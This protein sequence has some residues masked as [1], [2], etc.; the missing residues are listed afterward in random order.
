MSTLRKTI[1]DKFGH[2]G[3]Y[4][5]E[6]H[7]P[8]LIIFSVIIAVLIY[9]IPNVTI[10]TSTNAMIPAD[11]PVRK[12]YNRFKE[13]FGREDLIFILIRSPE[14]FHEHFLGRLTSFHHELEEKVPYV[15][16]VVSMINARYIF[17]EKDELVVE[18]LLYDRKSPMVTMPMLKQRVMKRPGYVNYLI[19]EDGKYTALVVEKEVYVKTNDKEPDILKGFENNFSDETTEEQNYFDEKQ[20]RELITAIWEIV[21]QYQSDD[22]SI[23]VTGGMLLYDAL[24]R[25]VVKDLFRSVFLG[26][27]VMV[28]FLL[29]LFRNYS[30]VVL[31]AVIV[32]SSMLSTMGIMAVCGI[33]MKITTTMLPAF[34]LAVGVGDSVHILAIFYRHYDKEQNKKEAVIYSLSHSGLAIL[35]TTLTTAAGLLSFS[36]AELTVIADIGIFAAVGV[37]LALIFTIFLLPALLAAIPI[38]VSKKKKRNHRIVMDRI[39]LFFAHFSVSHPWKILI[40]TL[41]IIIVSI[42]F[43][44]Q[45]RV[46][47][48]V[49]NWFPDGITIKEDLLLID[50]KIKG[51]VS[52]EIVVDTQNPGGVYDPE[53]LNKI[54][55]LKGNISKI[56]VDKLHVGKIFTVNDIIKEIHEALH[57]NNEDFYSIPQ[58][59]NVIAQELLLFENSG[60]ND[61]D[62]IVDNR[63]QKTR[64]SIKTP[65]SD[66]VVFVD[67]IKEV[68]G[69]FKE[70]FGERVLITTTGVMAIAA[71]VITA[72]IETMIRSYG[73]AFFVISIMMIFL[74]GN[75]KIG[76]LS[77]VPNL[78][79]VL[80]VMG[81]MGLCDFP[82]DMVSL[83][84]GS[85]VIGLAVDDTVHFIYNF[86]KN[87]E[88]TNDADEAVKQTLLSTG[89]AM[90]ITSLVL[91]SGF[92]VVMFSTLTIMKGF[93][94]FTGLAV[95]L[96][97]MADFLTAP[98]FLYLLA[99][100]KKRKM[101]LS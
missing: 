62:R 59:R 66:A 95:L 25:F 32:V 38:T 20:T 44:F 5:Y 33:S 82:L 42:V 80:I 60:S 2:L 30:G 88:I 83:M 9:Q 6:R 43:I 15:R 24:N 36:F 48:Y 14:I 29:M 49:V 10:D 93:G 55:M 13:D 12:E 56:K 77:M 96:A 17:G 70:I 97:L 19:S 87:L 23:S 101:E 35:M 47:Q 1:E 89:R 8:V 75:L 64:F 68:Q 85:I 73:I 22:F 61:L 21:D 63:V 51:T 69:Q 72:A 11:D 84:I 78:L 31:P 86:R 40:M 46:S 52:L 99:T 26:F 98:A 34:L 7:R 57:E 53:V 18:K 41:V 65:D 16:S 92:F 45:L 37:V 100:A 81:V 28:F 54:E 79:P 4:L 90:L 67:F 3:K 27:F 71:R 58:N 74:A 94:F 91:S 50:E 76:V 39:L